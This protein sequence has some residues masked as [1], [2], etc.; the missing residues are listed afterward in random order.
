MRNYPQHLLLIEIVRFLAAFS[1]LIWHYQHFTFVIFEP[2]N[3]VVADQ[4]FYSIFWPFYEHGQ[5]GVQVFWTVS[6]FI[7]F[8][9]YKV[10]LTERFVDAKQF[11]ILRFSRLYPLHFVTLILVALLQLVYFSQ[12][13][14][15]FVYKQN[16]FQH[17]ILQILFA[18]NWI[19]NEFSFNGPVWSVSAE[20]LVYAFFY[21]YVARFKPCIRNTLLIF[22]ACVLLSNFHF[23]NLV[24]NCLKY[25][26]LGGLS[27]E[28]YKVM[29]GKPYKKQF[30]RNILVG[31][32][33][34]LLT[35]F[36]A[37][38]LNIL[39]LKHYTFLLLI[40]I[41][42][43]LY[44]S[45]QKLKVTD[46]AKNLI[47]GMGNLT[48]SSYLTHF[49]VQ[50]I[51]VI[52]YSYKRATIPFYDPRFFFAYLLIVLVI[53]LLTYHFFERPLQKIIRKYWLY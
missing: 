49:P 45:P 18:S 38:Q 46:R 5:L 4:P 42:V 8:W 50:L 19:N 48:Y 1:V 37:Y 9:K 35:L 28:C 25:F 33:I 20:T 43:L 21:V 52:W 10:K 39:R 13:Q 41:S 15:Y 27:F 30:D 51:I 3:F 34:F 24:T 7:F 6:G 53:S 17:F 29:Q 2:V 26:F 23:D 14:N 40:V 11:F 47:N 32:G 36:A 16:D 31:L 22:L 12:N 44:F